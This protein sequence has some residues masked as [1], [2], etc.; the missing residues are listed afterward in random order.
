MA[1]RIPYALRLTIAKNIRYCRMQKFPGR[2]GEKRCA[3]AFGV[4]L[5]QWCQWE[6][7][8]RM[9]E[10]TRLAQIAQ[11]FDVTVE[12]MRSGHHESADNSDVSYHDIFGEVLG[13]PPLAQWE[14]PPPGSP[15][16]F[17]WLARDFCRTVGKHG[18]RVTV[19]LDEES[20][21]S[22]AERIRRQVPGG[23]E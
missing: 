8:A 17:Y 21:H 6:R 7:A 15:A 2:G 19:H 11:F 18:V 9:P 22:L 20:L 1:G 23:E 5:Q 10:E 4:H 16:S 14:I 12:W 3:E 13:V